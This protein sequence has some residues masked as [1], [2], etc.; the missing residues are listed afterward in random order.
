MV[1]EHASTP[2]AKNG[3]WAERLLSQLFMKAGWEV[4][5][6]PLPHKPSDPDLR[7]RR[8]NADYVVEVKS[9]SEGRSDRLIPLWS[10]ACLQAIRAARDHDSSLA[11]VAAPRIPPRVAEQVLEFA[12]E[13]APQVAAG[14]IDSAGLRRF[15]GAG[16]EELNSEPTH[17]PATR[18]AASPEPANIFSDLNQWMLKVLLAPEIPGAMLAAPRSRYRN[19][20]QLARAAEVSVMSASR[21]V[22]QLQRE[23]YLHESKPYLDLVRREE[24]FRHWQSAGARRV[25]ETSFRFLVRGNAQSQL[26]RLLRGSRSCLALF[27]AADALDVGFVH[28]VPPHV[29]VERLRDAAGPA[30]NTVVPTEPGEQPDLIVREAPAPGSVF[31]G[32]VMRDSMPVCDIVQ[33]WLDVGS[34]PARGV[35]QADLIRRKILDPVIH[36]DAQPA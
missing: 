22:R 16:V 31:R 9:A 13:F 3:R 26:A 33:V 5:S 8:G 29:Y 34:H 30:W 20:A 11:V 12:A 10:Q 32:M 23:G 21:L 15:R 6:D 24:L 18:R 28:G 1:S 19:A 35:E 27:A 4:V 7:M 36:N 2:A 14:V 25:K 17:A